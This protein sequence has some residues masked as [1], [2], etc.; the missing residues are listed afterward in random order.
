MAG[1]INNVVVSERDI[2][3][4]IELQGLEPAQSE[5]Q[6]MAIVEKM[7]IDRGR[8]CY[9]EGVSPNRR[10]SNSAH[11]F[12]V[13]QEYEEVKKEPIPEPTEMMAMMKVMMEQN[14]L[15]AAQVAQLAKANEPAKLASIE[16]TESEDISHL[17]KRS[18]E[19]RDAASGQS[20]KIPKL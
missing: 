6:I 17:D 5:D 15:L 2:R 14:A 4:K 8:T 7:G 16:P 9:C 18:K 1:N 19:Y 11:A 20:V 3:N 13:P 10:W 12:G